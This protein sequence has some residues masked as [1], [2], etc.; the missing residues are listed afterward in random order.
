VE[1]LD[2]LGVAGGVIAIILLWRQRNDPAFCRWC[3]D[4]EDQESAEYVEAMMDAAE[5]RREDA[6][7]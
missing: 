5:A 7:A 1:I 6:H 3:D 4:A 2:V